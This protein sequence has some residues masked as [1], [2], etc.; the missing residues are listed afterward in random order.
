MSS[1]NSP[2]K[3]DPKTLFAIVITSTHSGNV[4]LNIVLNPLN[5]TPS[6]SSDS[7]IEVIPPD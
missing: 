7:D 1:M 6:L 5:Q 3:S 4:N 2:E